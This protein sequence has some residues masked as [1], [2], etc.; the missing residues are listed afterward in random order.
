MAGTISINEVFAVTET[1]TETQ[2]IIA[3]DTAEN[4]RFGDSVSISGDTVII[5]ASGDDDV[6][7]LDPVFCNSGSAYIFTRSNDDGVWSEQAKITASDAAERDRF[8]SSV[9]IS[10]DTAIVGALFDDNNAGTSSG[11]AYIFTRSDGDGMWSEQAKI[12][13]SDA[14]EGDWFGSS[15]SISG[16]I[17]I[18]GAWRDDDNGFDSGSAYI[19]T[20]SGDDGVW[21]EQAKITASDAAEFNEF[22]GSVSISGDTAIVGALG[23]DDKAT[24]SGSVYI[25]TRTDDGVWS[26]QA[27]ITAS[28]GEAF[29]SF[30][31]SVSISGDIAIVGANGDDDAPDCFDS[32]C[33]SGAAYI[34]TR[35][36]GDGVWSEQAKITSSDAAADDFF[37]GSVSISGDT[38]IVGALGDDTCPSDP[39]CSSGAAYIFTRS[40]GDGVWSEQ[41]KITASDAAA[42]DSFGV[43]V[44][45]SG[46]IAIVG[47]NGDNDNG[48]D[49]G[50]AYIFDL[51][52][53]D[54]IPPVITLNGDDIITLEVGLDT[55]TEQGATVTDDD[56]TYSG[57][58]TISGD[59]VDDGIIGTYVVTYDA[60]ADAAGNV[61][62]QVTRTVNVVAEV[63]VDEIPI[64]CDSIKIEN[65]IDNR[66]RQ[67]GSSV[68]GTTNNDL[69]LASDLG[70]TVSGLE[71]NDCIVG[72]D[73]RDKLNGNFG[74]DIILGNGGPDLISGGDGDDKIS[75][76][77]DDDTING[78]KGSDTISGGD[79]NDLIEGG[80][81]KDRISGGDGN[82]LIS[83]GDGDDKISGGDDIDEIDGSQGEDT[84]IT[85]NQDKPTV[86]CENII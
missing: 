16:D 14:A 37:G 65:I 57:M 72:G 11:S 83:G 1:L 13:A 53:E 63:I 64:E 85:D 42:D 3:S 66:D 78:G 81:D 21:S 43:S 70:D 67:L 68:T 71:G 27:K 62:L 50:S 74:N 59:A 34:F 24:N 49:S 82:D 56:P 26:E 76:S 23:D 33:E 55:Y 73:S 18:V 22:G 48:F 32:F 7:P 75:G 29:D 39:F 8:G 19:F 84:C 77:N 15:V 9:S 6:C 10:G 5:G 46:D 20:R 47:V 60:P 61:P 40:D 44:S 31:V 4:D 51:S 25:F 28:D 35:S 69:I 12:T 45:I 86:N 54:T 80:D 52:T 38:A 36:D 58:I 2:K 79:G 41:A 30:G 17:A